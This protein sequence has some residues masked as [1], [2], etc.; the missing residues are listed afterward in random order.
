MCEAFKLKPLYMVR[1]F[2]FSIKHAWDLIVLLLPSVE[3]CRGSDN[4]GVG[5]FAL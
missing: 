3:E 4:V 2:Q 5:I 1:W